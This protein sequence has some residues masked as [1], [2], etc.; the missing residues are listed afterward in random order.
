MRIGA[1]VVAGF[2]LLLPLSLSADTTYTYTGNDFDQFSGPDM[3]HNPNGYYGYNNF[4]GGEFT[5]GSA[6][7]PDLM[8]AL[9]VPESYSFTDGTFTLS[10]SG[11]PTYF[12]PGIFIWTDASGDIA[13]WRVSIDTPGAATY[14]FVIDTSNVPGSVFDEGWY[15]ASFDYFSG[16]VADDPGTWV[17]A[18]TPEPRSLILMGTGM[19]ALLAAYRRRVRSA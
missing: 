7:A 18:Q 12:P 1:I 11:G 14:Q 6:L 9:I 15:L 2:M 16:S 5:V 19:L 8:D 4:V 17:A 13:E 10:N 3:D